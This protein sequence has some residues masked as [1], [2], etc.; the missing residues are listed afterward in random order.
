MMIDICCGTGSVRSVGNYYEL[1]DLD[2]AG[3]LGLVEHMPRQ[4]WFDLQPLSEM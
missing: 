4:H 1:S 2:E 3:L